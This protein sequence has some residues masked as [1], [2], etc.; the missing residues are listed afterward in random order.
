MCEWEEVRRKEKRLEM[1]EIEVGKMEVG[2]EMM[3]RKW[4]D[5]KKREEGG[6]EKKRIGEADG[7]MKKIGVEERREFVNEG[8][9]WQDVGMEGTVKAEGRESEWAVGEWRE[10]NLVGDWLEVVMNRKKEE[11]DSKEKEREREQSKERERERAQRQRILCDVLPSFSKSKREIIF[12]LWR[13]LNF[14]II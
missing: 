5:Q 4:Q 12:I 10:D 2:V 11:G 13:K 9:N 8:E 1:M 14:V 7:E 3:M 6:E